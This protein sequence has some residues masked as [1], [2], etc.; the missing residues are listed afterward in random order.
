[1]L[2]EQASIAIWPCIKLA[3]FFDLSFWTVAFVS[4]VSPSF[5]KKGKDVLFRKH[6]LVGVHDAYL[7]E[8]R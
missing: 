8:V 1:M 3:S 4:L 2:L 7:Q 6:I 5:T